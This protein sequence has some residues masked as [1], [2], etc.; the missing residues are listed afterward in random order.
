M[1]LKLRAPRQPPPIPIPTLH[2]AAQALA[3]FQQ[4][5]PLDGGIVGAVDLAS[6]A[7]PTAILAAAA[8]EAL[9][10]QGGAA[11][12]LNSPELG[13]RLRAAAEAVAAL[14]S[15]ARPLL[16]AAAEAL[17]EAPWPGRRAPD[18]LGCLSLLCVGV[19]VG[20]AGLPEPQS[21]A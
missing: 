2:I 16:A 5:Q 17:A 9:G 12:V 11:A 21:T 19:G 13:T 8:A 15:V 7:A 10:W 3:F 4:Q 1:Q 18:V 20:V 6:S 14:A